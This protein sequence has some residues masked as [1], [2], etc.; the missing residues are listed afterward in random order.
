MLNLNLNQD[1]I[2]QIDDGIEEKLRRM[3]EYHSFKAAQMETTLGQPGP[4]VNI[5]EWGQ[6]PQIAQGLAYDPESVT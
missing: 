2:P 5:A 6:N 4:V 3:R 1:V